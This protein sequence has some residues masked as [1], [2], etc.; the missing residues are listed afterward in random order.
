LEYNEKNGQIDANAVVI[1]VQ[2]A[3][4]CEVATAFAKQAKYHILLEKPMSVSEQEC[5][6]I[7]EA[8]ESNKVML[9][10]CHVLRY[11][12]LTQRIKHIINEED[13]IGKIINVQHLEPVGHWHFAHV[14]Y[15]LL[16]FFIT[17]LYYWYF[18]CGLLF[19]LVV[20]YLMSTCIVE[21]C[22]WQ[23]AQ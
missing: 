3:M 21:L 22:T 10:V 15:Q 12:L 11:S 23:L 20:I 7:V 2:D 19:F 13:G 14:C 1:A 6:Q 8:V 9:A 5:Q 17:N 16:L 18:Y 4:H